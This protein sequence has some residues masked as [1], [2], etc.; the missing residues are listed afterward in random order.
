MKYIFNVNEDMNNGRDKEKNIMKIYLFFYDLVQ[1]HKLQIIGLIASFLLL[2]LSSYRL[3]II[4]K[5]I[6]AISISGFVFS[7]L[8]LYFSTQ[9]LYDKI[10]KFIDYDL[11]V[12]DMIVFNDSI[13]DRL[14]ES[15]IVPAIKIYY[16]VRNVSNKKF[17]LIFNIDNQTY[18]I[19]EIINCDKKENKIEK[20]IYSDKL[21]KTIQETDNKCVNEKGLLLA[22]IVL[23]KDSNKKEGE[24]I[25]E[26]DI[27]NSL[28]LSELFFIP[29]LHEADKD[30]NKK[31]N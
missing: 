2:Y 19:A 18:K 12:R 16:D 3:A 28:I 21:L 1:N 31:L 5:I 10:S 11:Y 17:A 9:R 22:S 14:E 20:K 25:T 4:L 30:T 24:I 27:D 13:N 7:A 26:N 15:S 6:L 23:L 8:D 29:Y